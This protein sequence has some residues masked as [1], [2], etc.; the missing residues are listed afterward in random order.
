MTKGDLVIAP[1]EFL[2]RFLL[3]NYPDPSLQPR[4]RIVNPPVDLARFDPDAVDSGFAADKRR[5]W[6]VGEGAFCLMSVGRV[7]PVK[8][9]D[10]VIRDFAENAARKRADSRLVIVGGAD[11]RHQNHLAELKALA[12]SL[13][14]ADRV[15]FAGAQSKMPECISIA[16]E[17][18]C[19]NTKKPESFGL[20]V[21]EALAMNKPVRLL[22]EFGGAAE[23]ISSVRSHGGKNTR[24]AVRALYGFDAVARKTIAEYEGVLKIARGT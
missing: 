21:C 10:N 17:I 16:D 14:V 1:S 15:V 13:G 11:A 4:L 6:G 20:S 23:I 2:A 7:S 24:D 9:F 19:G 3:D 18:V 5:E 12:E 8:G 22:R